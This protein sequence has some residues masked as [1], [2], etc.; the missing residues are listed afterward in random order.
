MVWT[1]ATLMSLPNFGEAVLSRIDDMN[2]NNIFR[3]TIFSL[4]PLLG[5]VLISTSGAGAQ[6]A[7]QTPEFA[8]A[9]LQYVVYDGSTRAG[10][11]S[12]PGQSPK[13]RIKGNDLRITSRVDSTVLLSR[14][15][16]NASG[17]TAEVSLKQAPV[18]TSSISG[19]A[20]L[21]D[22]QHALVIGLEGGRVVLWQLD[23]GATRVVASQPVNSSSPL[24][25][26]V[27]GSEPAHVH[28]FW[29]HRTDS[30]W[31]ALG[32]AEMDKILSSW[33]QPL[34]FG[35]LLD[36]PQGS[37]VTFSNYR[38]GSTQMASVAT[39][40]PVMTAALTNGQ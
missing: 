16:D 35:L 36:G 32:N 14:Q 22:A 34:R 27:S 9:H 13:L 18:S 23:P 37:Q 5:V 21:S 38:A 10:W 30:A 26:R 20:V 29:R 19:L 15:A 25:F 4:I 39:D 33:H 31:H 24:E 7:A 1:L 8:A 11:Y 17:L 2:K 40:S 12:F 6:N 3:N 28:F